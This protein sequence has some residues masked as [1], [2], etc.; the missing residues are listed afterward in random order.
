MSQNDE[1]ESPDPGSGTRDVQFHVAPDLDYV[2]R[3][4]FNVFVGSGD[5]VIE[6]GNQHRAMPGH[7]TIA[8]RIVMTVGNAYGLIQT[9]QKT[10]EEAQIKLHEQI[11]AQ[12][13]SGR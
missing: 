4:V 3:D 2:Y 7:A 1:N 10:L 8:N 5:V 11:Q 6:F 9:L 12:K 13:K